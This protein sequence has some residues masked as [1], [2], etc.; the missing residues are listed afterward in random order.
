VRAHS[1]SPVFG[2]IEATR[3]QFTGARRLNDVNGAVTPQ[4]RALGIERH[5]EVQPLTRVGVGDGEQRRVGDVEIGLI[6]RDLCSVMRKGLRQS[7]ALNRFPVLGVD[8]FMLPDRGI[9]QIG[10]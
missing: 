5:E 1:A 6:K 4:L 10:A 2:I 8:C 7:V 9:N 3:Q